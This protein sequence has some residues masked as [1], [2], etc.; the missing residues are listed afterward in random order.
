MYLKFNIVIL[1]CASLTGISNHWGKYLKTVGS[2]WICTELILRGWVNNYRQCMLNIYY[3]SCRDLTSTAFFKIIPLLIDAWGPLSYS[4]LYAPRMKSFGLCD[5]PCMHHFLA[6]LALFTCLILVWLFL[7]LSIHHRLHCDTTLFPYCTD[8]PYALK[9]LLHPQP[10]RYGL[11]LAALLLSKWQ[12]GWHETH[13]RNALSRSNL[14]HN[15]RRE[16]DPVYC[17]MLNQQCNQQQKIYLHC[18]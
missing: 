7:N 11:V 12:A 15:F 3:N 18:R 10:I 13:D 1:F 5:N 14:H 16:W 9:H 6:G 8:I 17:V 2:T 4:L